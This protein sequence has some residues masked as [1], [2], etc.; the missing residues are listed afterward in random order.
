MSFG[1][2]VVAPFDGDLDDYQR[3]LLDESKR[4]RELAKIE[5][6]TKA[7]VIAA[8]TVAPPVSAVI[9]RPP[10]SKGSLQNLKKKLLDTEQRIAQLQTEQ[11]ALHQQ[12]SQTLPASD[13]AQA[14]KQLKTV[15]AELAQ[16]EE[17][18][19]ALGETLESSA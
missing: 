12:L 8:P 18:W 10:V 4:L 2:G 17:Q 9:A 7:A 5:A 3:Y 6:T 14:A 11:A 16:T 15:D 19:L 13:L 1:C